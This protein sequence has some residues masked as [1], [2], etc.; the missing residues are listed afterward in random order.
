MSAKQFNRT[1]FK[2]KVVGMLLGDA[3]LRVTR[4]SKNA[5]LQ[6]THCHAQAD[7]LEHK[8]EILR[9]LTSV[10]VRYNSSVLKGKTYKRAQL[11]TRVHPLYT[12]LH[13][14]MYHQGRKTVDTFCMKTISEEGLA[15][16]Y[17]DDGHLHAENG[18]Q[19]VYICTDSFSKTEQEM[20][21]HYLKKRFDVAFNVSRYR[22]TYRMRLRQKDNAAFLSIVTPFFVD[23]MKYKLDLFRC[24]QEMRQ[25]VCEHCHSEF[26]VVFNKLGRF[27]SQRCF[28]ESLRS[29]TG[30]W[31]K[32]NHS[33]RRDS[34]I[35]VATQVA[36]ESLQVT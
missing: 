3:G 14:R 12:S 28:Q 19:A 11:E 16:W 36:G 13:R 24:S 7:Y 6:M 8:A 21:A 4:T 1:E 31:R 18:S 22:K 15:F 23:C 17:M 27:C 2:S 30:D 29:A 20:M 32:K 34:L 26:S 33:A 5:L 25:C 9:G 35:P 10:K